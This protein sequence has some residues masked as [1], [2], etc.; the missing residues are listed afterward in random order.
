MIKTKPSEDDSELDL[1]ALCPK[2]GW[3]LYHFFKMF[4]DDSEAHE[5]LFAFTERIS[6]P[7]LYKNEVK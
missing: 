6:A 4:F 3:F 1:S 5:L 2:V 7:S